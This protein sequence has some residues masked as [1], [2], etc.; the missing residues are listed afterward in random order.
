MTKKLV[1]RLQN[2]PTPSEVE[3]LLKSEIITTDEAREILFSHE[4][5]KVRDQKSLESEI[6]FLRE[7]VEKLS[8]NNPT[9]IIETIKYVEKPYQ[10]YDWYK[11][12]YQ[13]ESNIVLC[14]SQANSQYQSGA[15]LQAFNAIQT[16]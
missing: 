16:F 10:R 9:T 1:W 11:P 5:E 4:D 2:R 15:Q 8:K 7:L 3:S 14:Q 13:W 12:Y 6:K